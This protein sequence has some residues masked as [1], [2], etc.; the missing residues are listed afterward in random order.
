MGEISS[1]PVKMYEHKLLSPWMESPIS[2]FYRRYILGGGVADYFNAYYN[3]R[4]TLQ[5]ELDKTDQK[6]IAFGYTLLTQEQWDK[7]LMLM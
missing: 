3:G 4:G 7:Y 1:P 6:L 5:D 2:G